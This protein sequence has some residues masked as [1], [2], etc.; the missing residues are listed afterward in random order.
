MVVVVVASPTVRWFTV[1]SV[2]IGHDVQTCSDQKYLVSDQ[3]D[4][5]RLTFDDAASWIHLNQPTIMPV[6]LPATL[7][8]ADPD[9][10]GAQ[11]STA[12]YS[13]VFVVVDVNPDGTPANAHVGESSGD[14]S[15]DD[16][17][18]RAVE[19]STFSPARLPA[20]VGGTPVG[21][22]L[23]F[24]LPYMPLDAKSCRLSVALA[25]LVAV[26]SSH[27][28]GEYLIQIKSAPKTKGSF[29]IRLTAQ[30]E[31]GPPIPLV[32]ND[33]DTTEGQK[34]SQRILVVLP[35]PGIKWFAVDGDDSPRGN[36]TCPLEYRSL[37]RSPSLPTTFDDAA[38][39]AKLAQP[40][41]VTISDA[42]FL[43]RAH[44]EYPDMAKEQNDQGDVAVAFVVAPDGTVSDA[45]IYQS[46]GNALL[47]EASMSAISRSTFK[48]ARLPTA[49]GGGAIASAYL[50]IY[51]FSLNQ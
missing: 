21:V 16:A 33:F 25:Q 40:V 34:N 5:T 39:W 37:V 22:Q 28:S 18:R 44:P 49:Y 36:E 43:N 2:S 3:H 1:D 6:S 10:S 20:A 14:T 35:T 17:A 42:D 41:V 46:S 13:S 15:V 51:T 30:P 31:D 27:Q 38:P 9:Y 4:N 50:V 7:R 45:W 26:G 12:V 29:A 19:E 23:G 32:V 24:S 8:R 11:P 47:D 48:P